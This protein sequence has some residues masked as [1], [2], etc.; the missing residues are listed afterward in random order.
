MVCGLSLIYVYF[1]RVFQHMSMLVIIITI[2]IMIVILFILIIT[3]G[4]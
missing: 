1:H 2:I 3:P 4:R